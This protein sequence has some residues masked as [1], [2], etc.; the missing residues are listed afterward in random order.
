MNVHNDWQAKLFTANQ[1]LGKQV[2]A[3]TLHYVLAIMRQDRSVIGQHHI[4]M[5]S[6]AIKQVI[7]RCVTDRLPQ[8]PLETSFAANGC[9]YFGRLRPRKNAART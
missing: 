4:A 3:D 9:K 5:V 1:A 7:H 6:A 8:F 2:S